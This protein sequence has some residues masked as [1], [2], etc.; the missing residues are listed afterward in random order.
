MP[1]RS[2][3]HQGLQSFHTFM[4][5]KSA[6]PLMPHMWLHTCPIDHISV[7]FR[8]V[9]LLLFWIWFAVFIKFRKVHGSAI[10]DT[11]Y[12]ESRNDVQSFIVLWNFAIF[13]RSDQYQRYILARCKAKLSVNIP[14]VFII[15]ENAYAWELCKSSEWTRAIPNEDSDRSEIVTLIIH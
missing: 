13:M 8:K 10:V 5:A 9:I 1:K 11:L 12:Y 3:F 15:I 6:A 14:T 4:A 2:Y 7:K